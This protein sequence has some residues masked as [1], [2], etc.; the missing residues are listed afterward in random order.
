MACAE[1]YKKYPSAVEI[2]I[3]ERAEFRDSVYPTH[4]MYRAERRDRLDAIVAAGVASGEF[5]PVNPTSTIDAYADLLF[6]SFVNGCIGGSRDKLTERIT[7][8]VEIFV[9]GLL[10]VPQHASR[11]SR[12]SKRN[13]PLSLKKITP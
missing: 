5:R 4:L 2:M 10:L 7:A 13:S 8:S 9:N 11:D 3:M 6:G 1:F 12:R